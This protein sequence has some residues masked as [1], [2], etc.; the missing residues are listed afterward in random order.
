MA[1]ITLTT[2]FGVK[3]PYMGE[4][5][6]AIL[7]LNPKA[8]I[9]DVTHSITRHSVLEG[10]FVMEQVAKYSRKQNYLNFKKRVQ[11]KKLRK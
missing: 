8:V 5:K 7:R 10:S 6:V 3:D 2:D 9:V 1:M 11:R 4:M